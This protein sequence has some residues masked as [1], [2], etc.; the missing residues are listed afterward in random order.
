MIWDINY[1]EVDLNVYTK[2]NIDKVIDSTKKDCKQFINQRAAHKRKLTNIN[3][4]LNDLHAA[5]TLKPVLFETLKADAFEALAKIENLDSQI[6]NAVD[7]K[8]LYQ[9][10]PTLCDRQEQDSYDYN[11]EIKSNILAFQPEKEISPSKPWLGSGSNG[12]NGIKADPIPLKLKSFDGT[13]DF[14]S[15]INKFDCAI[16]NNTKFNDS[17]R[18]IYL[19]NYLEGY[20]FKLIE[21]FSI[22]DENY[23]SARDI[24][25]KEFYNVEKLIDENYDK[26]LT[27]KLSQGGDALINAKLYISNIKVYIYDLKALG[28]N[29]MAAEA[30]GSSLIAHIIFSK[31]PSLLKR[32]LTHKCANNYPTLSQIFDNYGDCVAAIVRTQPSKI[33]KTEKPDIKIPPFKKIPKKVPAIMPPQSS[34]QSFQVAT[35]G[36]NK[37]FTPPPCKLC[38]EQS[39]TMSKCAH[40]AT[41]DSRI[42]RCEDL[43]LCSLCSS[44]KHAT[45]DCPQI[46]TKPC[47]FC[48]ETSHISPLCPSMHSKPNETPVSTSNLQ[49]NAVICMHG[50]QTDRQET[51]PT[52]RDKNILPTISLPV[53]FNNREHIIR[54]LLDTGS[55]KSILAKSV[56]EN[57]FGVKNSTDDTIHFSTIIGSKKLDVGEINMEIILGNTFKTVPIMVVPDFCISFEIDGLQAVLGNIL[58]AGYKLADF[59]FHDHSLR[60]KIELYG[61]LGMDALRQTR[62]FPFMP[63]LFG[64]VMRWA[65][66]LGYGVIPV[67]DVTQY[68]YPAQIKSILLE[69]MESKVIPIMSDSQVSPPVS[70]CSE[71]ISET[72]LNSILSPAPSYYSLGDKILS[73]SMM[74]QG[75]E[76]SISLESIGILPEE[77]EN[78]EIVERFQKS[79]IY[80]NNHYHVELPWNE[81]I[82]Q[83]PSNRGICLQILDKT[84][85]KLKNSNN[86]NAYDAVFKQQLQDGI[87]EQIDLPHPNS[88]AHIFLPHRAVIKTQEQVT[89][90]VRPVFN[91]SLRVNGN[92]SLNDASYKGPNLLNEISSLVLRFRSN[93]YVLLSDIKQAFLN[94]F[95]K[96]DQDR[97]RFCFFWQDD[98]GNLITYRYATLAFGFTM[99]PFALNYVVKNHVMGYPE[100]S[101][102]KFLMNNMYVDNLVITGNNLDDL[103]SIYSE[104]V[105][106]MKEG[107][108]DLRSWV[109]N[110]TYL[111]NIFREDQTIINH[112]CEEDKVLGYVYNRKFDVLKLNPVKFDDS[113]KTKRSILSQISKI[114][115]NLSLFLPVTISGRILMREIWKAKFSWDE[116]ISAE[117]IKKWD[118]LKIQYEQIFDIEIPRQ[119]IDDSNNYDLCLL[120][121]ASLSAYAF[122]AYAVSDRSSNLIFAKAKVAPLEKRK[123]PSLEMLSVCMGLKCVPF[124]LNSFNNVKFKKLIVAMDA[125]IALSW[126]LS[127]K[128]NTKSV[129]V[130]NRIREVHTAKTEFSEVFDSVEFHYIPTDDNSSDL[131]TRGVTTSKFIE[132][133]QFWLEGPQWLIEGCRKWPDFPL[134][135]ISPEY[136]MSSVIEVQNPDNS[137]IDITSYSCLH[138]LLKIISIIFKFYFNIRKSDKDPIRHAKH[139]CV[140]KMQSESFSNEIKFLKNDSQDKIV[141]PLVNDLNL[142]IDSDGILRSKGRISKSIIQNPDVLNPIL[143]GKSHHL[144]YLYILDAHLRLQ[145]LGVQTTVNELRMKGIWVP[146]IRQAVK[147]VVDACVTC[148]KFN[149]LAHKYPRLTDMHVSRMKFVIPYRHTGIDYSGHIFVYNETGQRSKMYILLYTCLNVRAIHLQLVPSLSTVDFVLAFQ[150]FIN[151]YGLPSHIYTDNGLS[152]ISGGNWIEKAFMSSEFSSNI[153]STDMKHIKIPLYSAWVGSLWERMMRVLKNCLYKVVGKAKLTQPQLLTVLSNIQNAVNSR[154]LTYRAG[155]E[156]LQP[157]TP[158]SFFKHSISSNL[159]GNDDLN[160]NITHEDVNEQMNIQDD[161]FEHFRQLWYTEYLTSLR[162]MDKNLYQTKFENKIKVGDVVLIKIPNR[163]RPYWPL[164]RVTKAIIGHDGKIR[165]VELKKGNGSVDTHSISHL[166]PLELSLSHSGTEPDGETQ[167]IQAKSNQTKPSSERPQEITE[168][169]PQGRPQRAAAQK[170]RANLKRLAP[171][172]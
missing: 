47:L 50:A 124:I 51:C 23:K 144:T 84:I 34:L 113:S 21:H 46:L 167:P 52:Y 81:K 100:D 118:K 5:G 17:A 114:Y 73:D 54:F 24:L 11:F 112:N 56:V 76:Y 40:Y 39:H 132:N 78:D 69:K 42:K 142:F 6:I 89:T 146:K 106:R 171:Q 92:P 127:G 152:F 66:G 49:S 172:I 87:I 139:F 64:N 101:C 111:E 135:C 2:E 75:L 103:R 14:K 150:Q 8:G 29:Y 41:Y 70:S 7:T 108:F 157:I 136:V 120:C 18:L 83:V 31:L 22:N 165:S 10:D 121:D 9:I 60:N 130:K 16:G 1:D 169:I 53:K 141:P 38:G 107:G 25:N 72:L 15:F 155:N 159:C 153:S 35:K 71:N 133:L 45:V 154:P 98:Q 82:N 158:N 4:R 32:E 63:C 12:T 67:G 104:S 74:E 61:I 122:N 68:L 105:K 93:K 58:R 44:A 110:S 27:E 117:F 96:T 48:K 170:A 20:A 109:S 161:I 125:Q 138:K 19:K 156:D 62:G 131:A 148:K 116:K 134:D 65:D 129:F 13:G 164:G 119:A 37:K 55:Q 59:A 99:S 90:K 140:R 162:Q 33:I 97:N 147:K 137:V 43:K 80:K 36:G 86:Y 26:I 128:T 163:K 85:L 160:I 143:F 166:Y 88:K 95:L 94:I 57:L 91:A 3:K 168:E 28:V 151:I 77:K 115:D 30:I 149:A 126:I 123:L 145:H 79:I 102:S